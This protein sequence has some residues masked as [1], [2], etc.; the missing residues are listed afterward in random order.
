[1]DISELK[2]ILIVEDSSLIGKVLIQKLKKANFTPL[3]AKSKKEAENLLKENRDIFAS[4][5][6]ISLPD[7]PHG[8]IVDYVLNEGIPVIVLS[9]RSDDDTIDEMNEKNI[10]D[11][12][13]KNREE[14][15][16]YVVK[17]LIMMRRNVSTKALVVE[18]SKIYRRTIV[19][20]MKNLLFQVYEAKDGDEALALLQ[21][22][23]DIKILV[24][25]YYM[26]NMDGL[27]LTTTLRRK[28]KK[29]SLVI[30]ACTGK[31]SVFLSAKFLKLG[32][33]DYI[34]KPFTKEEFNYRII[35][36][37]ELL[38]MIE[39]LKQQKEELD[40]FNNNLQK[41]VEEETRKNREKQKMLEIQSRQAQMGEMIAAI[42]HQWRQPLHALSVTIQK[43]KV[44]YAMKELTE[45][46][47]D[48]TIQEAMEL[49]QYMSRTIDDF[50]NFFQKDTK[51]SRFDIVQTLRNVVRLLEP[52]L[53]EYNITINLHTDKDTIPYYGYENDLSQVLVNIINNAKDELL[54]AKKSS[55][56]I[57]IY[58]NVEEENIKIVIQDNGRGIPQEI[59]YKIF[60]P[61]F[62]T[63]ENLNGT[64]LG[65]YM[66]KMIVERKM[67]GKIYAENGKNG[68][69]FI[70]L[71]PR[72]NVENQNR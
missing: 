69:R 12:I 64:G 21:E 63:K 25:D 6:D 51:K 35:Q 32:A 37:I 72:T 70:I 66:A 24:T 36:N 20:Y 38:Y 55:K 50:R 2:K 8:E 52:I 48:Q 67:K 27:E 19:R 59:I 31:D 28:R 58:V 68:A 22:R 44:L 10:V 71:L 9:A 42:A 47:L 43:L 46:T 7:A 23:S 34:V 41:L 11:Y 15:I 29:D 60:E 13:I 17:I 16:D 18:D 39:K 5:L 1:M 45:E 49:I 26:P 53:G 3:W 40:N 4:V 14:D 30:I 33:N 56:H 61:Y 57:D 65:L 54:F 62:S